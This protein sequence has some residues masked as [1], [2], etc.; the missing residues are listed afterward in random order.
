M[1]APIDRAPRVDATA[2]RVRHTLTVSKSKLTLLLVVA[3]CAGSGTLQRDAATLERP[4]DAPMPRLP[5]GGVACGVCAGDFA[6][7]PDPVT[8]HPDALDEV[9]G[10]VESRRTPGVL[11]L[12]NDSGDSARFFAL[13]PDGRKVGEYHLRGAAAV[14]W[15]DL[16]VGPC[17]EGSCVYLGDIGD[18]DSARAEPTIYRVAE[19][20]TTA[21]E[22]VDLPWE[23]LPFRYPDGMHNAETLLVHPTTGDLYVVT[24]V[25]SGPSGVYVLRAPHAPGVVR[26]AERVASLELPADGGQLVTGGDLHPCADRLLLR[27]YIRLY[28]YERPAG[29]PFEALFTARPRVVAFLA[30]RQ[31]EAAG[32]RVDG[33]GYVTVSEGGHAR[34]LRFACAAP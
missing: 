7:Q 33:R 24:K 4:V 32:W 5:D 28:E 12:H 8:V 2:R 22:D 15:E 23:A 13:G 18:N 17:P 9:S 31:G 1:C 3:A 21:G 30:E 11:F 19:P 6:A 10:V 26:T 14:D 20:P 34:V 27:T 25:P 29:A 16:A